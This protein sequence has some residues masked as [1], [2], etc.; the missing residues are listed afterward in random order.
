MPVI[1]D[2]YNLLHAS[3]I[4]AGGV[5]P[6]T[7]ERARLALLNFLAESLPE[8]E[9]S[10]TTVVFDAADAPPGVPR[11][12]KHRGIGVRFSS[13]YEN[14]DAQ[15]EELIAHHSHPRRLTVVS[16]DHRIQR[17]ARRRRARAIDSGTWYAELCQQRAERRRAEPAASSRPPV[18]LLS[19]DVEYWLRQFGGASVFTDVIREE[20]ERLQREER[21]SGR[22][23]DA[24]STSDGQPTSDRE[25]AEEP[26][27]K[28]RTTLDGLDN[29]FPPGYAEDIEGL[30]DL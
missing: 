24:E 16:S 2:G 1:I 21:A 19:E 5:G 27:Q 13:G 22:T 15:I 12:A 30:D 8:E 14:A 25:T 4:L 28:D 29:P 23:A 11:A 6:H 7:L 10:R 20:V 9:I 17:A 26:E 3:G 18:P